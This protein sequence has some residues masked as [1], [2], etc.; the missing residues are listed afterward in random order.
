MKV[1]QVMQADLIERQLS[2]SGVISSITY[3]TSI[4]ARNASVRAFPIFSDTHID[5]QRC[6]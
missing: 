2:A 6:A 5:L 3:I 1:M 4:G